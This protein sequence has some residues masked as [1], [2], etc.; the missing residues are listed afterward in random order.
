MQLAV[1]HETQWSAADGNEEA[2]NGTPLHSVPC[3]ERKNRDS[4][5][6]TSHGNF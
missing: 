2:Q 4:Q 6:V 1:R 3:Y 5:P